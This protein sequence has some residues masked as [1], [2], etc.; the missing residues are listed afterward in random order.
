[1]RNKNFKQKNFMNNFHS[2]KV[3]N[4]MKLK[5]QINN[6]EIDET[7]DESIEE[8]TNITKYEFESQHVQWTL[9]F[10]LER[11]NKQ[12]ILSCTTK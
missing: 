9:G 10:L 7:S 6:N 5:E 11:I 1:M 2:E 3:R 12:K 4:P 8:L